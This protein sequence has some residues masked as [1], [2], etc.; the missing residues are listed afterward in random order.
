[1]AQA[2]GVAVQPQPD[3]ITALLRRLRQGDEG[4]AEKLWWVVYEE[5]R[6]IA[7][8]YMRKEAPG[9]TLQTTALVHE[10][11]LRLSDPT[12]VD[13]Q[14]RAHF[15]SVVA[16]VMRRVLIDHARA[17]L[18]DKRGAGAIKL[19]LDWV[20]VG[21][22]PQKLEEILAV[23]EMLSRLEEFDRQQARIMEL[24]YFAG[25]TVDETAT[26]LGLSSRT[27]DREWAMAS[28]WLRAEISR[29]G[30]A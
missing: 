3:E 9:H 22:T 6:R 7:R 30:A 12:R 13:W 11:W 26:A 17:R 27:V 5:L 23:D 18:A 19:S 14:D 24:R 28:A 21:A 25:M 20:E 10:A 16:Q 15:Y 4:A 29:K 8:A 2:L 1:M